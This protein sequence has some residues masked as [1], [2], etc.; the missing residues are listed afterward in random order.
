MEQAVFNN[1]RKLVYDKSGIDLKEGKKAMVSARIGKRL[2]SLRLADESEYLDYLINDKLGTE[3]VELLNVIST[4]V[5]HFYR[6]SAHFDFFDNAV[7]AWSEKGQTK[8]R[9]WSAACSSG[10]E[11]YTMAI[12]FMQ[13]LR[14]VVSKCDMK[15]LAT[16]ISTK[17][18]EH[19]RNGIYHKQQ[20][21][22]VPQDL[23]KR[24]FQPM[25]KIEPDAYKVKDILR[26][27]IS[28]KRLNLNEPPFPMKGPF[29]II[30]C[31]NVMIYFDKQTKQ[32]L[33][34][35]MLDLLKK[36]GYLIIAHAE[37]LSGIA[38][39][40]EQVASAVYRKTRN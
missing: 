5:T 7:K 40:Y 20:L 19:A 25:R 15:I 28:F 30:F 11:P 12:S 21:E 13:A 39:K 36:G 37:T 16:D 33:V 9:F 18:L 8:F 27:S 23:V 38:G 34:T 24:Y 22:P 10:E 2:R 26:S 31:R 1:F 6:E 35:N 17:V 4:N 14:A 3:I 32:R 29:D